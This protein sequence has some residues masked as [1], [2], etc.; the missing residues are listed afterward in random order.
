[1]KLVLIISIEMYARSPSILTPG[2]SSVS[3]DSGCGAGANSSESRSSRNMSPRTALL[4]RPPA[5]SFLQQSTD[6]TLYPSREAFVRSPSNVS[7]LSNLSYLS[8]SSR[9]NST[10]KYF[11]FLYLSATFLW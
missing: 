3:S 10:W 7:N 11:L 5:M 1:M 9:Y 2:S 4:L 6:S 8:D